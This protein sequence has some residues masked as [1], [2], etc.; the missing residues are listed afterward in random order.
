MGPGSAGVTDADLAPYERLLSMIEQELALLRSGRL[1]A[2]AEAVEHRCAFTAELPYTPPPAARAALE[3]ASELHHLTIAE[4]EHSKESLL[5]AL[6][7]LQRT[8]RA[9]D[10]Y[11]P[12]RARRY[13]TTA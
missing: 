7:Q 1:D 3:R 6:T 2:L 8:R 9:S 5:A 11:A 12:A 4:A 13:S 10:G